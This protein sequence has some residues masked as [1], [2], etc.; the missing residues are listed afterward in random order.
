METVFLFG[1]S[2]QRMAHEKRKY[3]TAKTYRTLLRNLERFSGSRNLYF[4]NLTPAF[5]LDFRRYLTDHGCCNNTR[6][7]YF[8]HLQSLHR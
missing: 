1:N 4:S 7:L 6:L 5:L 3:E 8:R 2:C